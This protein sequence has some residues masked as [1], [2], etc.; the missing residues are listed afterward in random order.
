MV[1]F[2][3]GYR[4]SFGWDRGELDGQAA[5]A[6]AVAAAWVLTEAVAG[7]FH[8]WRHGL[9][10]VGFIAVLLGLR[11]LHG[12]LQNRLTTTVTGGRSPR[13]A[14]ESALYL[15]TGLVFWLLNRALAGWLE[16]WS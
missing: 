14:G 13:R 9:L 8:G 6:Y 7:D 11:E 12:V 4:G 5:G 3:G 1:R 16:G 10:A 15:L 2:S